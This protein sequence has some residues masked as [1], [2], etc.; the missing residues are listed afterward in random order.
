MICIY[1]H[2]L[3]LLL[4]YAMKI[5]DVKL[6]TNLHNYSRW[7]TLYVLELLNLENKNPEVELQLRSGGFS[8]HR[9]GRKFSNIGVD[10]TLEQTINA[11]AKNRLKG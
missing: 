11:E 7:V 10:M 9:S 4:H 6:L 8:V 3:Y 5:N 1:Y 2:I